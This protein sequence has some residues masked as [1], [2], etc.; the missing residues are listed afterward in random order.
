MR[1]LEL[2]HIF[3]C[4]EPN[5]PEAIALADSGLQEGRNRIHRGQGTANRCFF[6]HNAYLELLWSCNSTEIK[7]SL[8]QPLHLWERCHWRNIS[9]CPFGISLRLTN[10]SSDNLPF[11]T[12]QYCP[13]YLPEGAFIPIATNSQFTDEPL[14]FLSP[15][16]QSPA[17]VSPDQRPPLEHNVKLE[18]I[19]KIDV[20]LAKEKPFSAEIAILQSLGLANFTRGQ[21]YHLQ[22]EFDR[23]MNGK[24]YNFEPD[25]PLS[26]RW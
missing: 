14:I 13:S 16:S 3:I 24:T 9:A 4:V 21:S 10:N 17:S 22:L 5:A 12:W 25:L 20:S 15:V 19:T 2:D 11:S 6:F 26:F 23:G 7:S 1:E 18:R 8:V